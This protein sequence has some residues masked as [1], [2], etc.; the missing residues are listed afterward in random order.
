MSFNYVTIAKV[1][2]LFVLLLALIY[3][4]LSQKLD[5]ETDYYGEYALESEYDHDYHDYTKRNSFTGPWNKINS[6]LLA[7]KGRVDDIKGIALTVTAGDNRKGATEYDTPAGFNAKE[8]I[9]PE[10]LESFSAGVAGDVRLFAAS[11]SKIVSSL[12]IFALITEG[13]HRIINSFMFPK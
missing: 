6:M 9:L 10:V 2:L 11:S 12:I 5:A 1:H 7:F 8:T 3:V 4:S 13:E